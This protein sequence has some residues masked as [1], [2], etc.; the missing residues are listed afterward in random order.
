MQSTVDIAT[1]IVAVA[2]ADHNVAAHVVVADDVD[3]VVADDVD[4]VADDDDFDVV[5]Q[6]SPQTEDEVE[7]FTKIRNQNIIN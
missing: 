2:A 5:A 3:D 4:D 7:F 1:V 6:H